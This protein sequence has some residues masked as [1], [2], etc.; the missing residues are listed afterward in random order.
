[1]K[2]ATPADRRGHGDSQPD[3]V[4]ALLDRGPSIL[5][6]IR[7]CASDGPTDGRTAIV[8]AMQVSSGKQAQ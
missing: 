6:A 4:A 5:T 1:M 2:S 3:Q 8:T 7:L